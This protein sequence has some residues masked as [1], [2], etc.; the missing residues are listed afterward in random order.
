MSETKKGSAFTKKCKLSPELAAIMGKN[1]MPRQE[2]VKRMWA[3]IKERN[4]YDPDNKQ[5]AICDAELK[6]VFGVDR[7]R[8]FG[9]MKYLKD[10]IFSQ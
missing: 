2:V 7:F 10:H 4:L 9:M 1:E 5:F 3:I 6:K 8:T